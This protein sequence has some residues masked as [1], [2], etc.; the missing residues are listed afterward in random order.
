VAEF[1][2]LSSFSTSNRGKYI[3]NHIMNQRDMADK[4]NSESELPLSL[5]AD[6]QKTI[7]QRVL[8]GYEGLFG[9]DMIVECNGKVRPFV[10]V[11]LRRTMG[12]LHIKP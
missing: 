11:N 5:I 7:L 10:E 2:G 1:L 3:S 12:M 8:E 4:F 6:L 9:V